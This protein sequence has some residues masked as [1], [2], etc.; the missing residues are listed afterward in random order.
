MRPFRRDVLLV[1]NALDTRSFPFRLREAPAPRL[2]W[3]RAF[4]EIYNPTL[5]PRVLA[6]LTPSC[7]TVRLTMVGRDKDGSLSRVQRVAAELGVADRVEYSGPVPNAEIGACLERADIFLN[8]TNVDN[9]PLSVL[10]AQAAG[11]CV[12]ST[13]VGGLPYLLEDGKDALLVPRDDP[14]AM[15]GAVRR[16]IDEP[17]LGA[18]LSRNGRTKAEGFDW[19]CVLPMWESLFEKTRGGIVRG[20]ARAGSES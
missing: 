15:A 7:P 8:T 4:H 3:I 17:G 13:N 18:S 19:S 12:V 2:V 11:L 9:T 20:A 14:A 1:P 10:E 16:V 6:A 5:A